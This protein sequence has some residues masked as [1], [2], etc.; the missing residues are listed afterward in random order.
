V[1][2]LAA[3][4]EETLA[5]AVGVVESDAMTVVELAESLVV[6]LADGGEKYLLLPEGS[7]QALRSNV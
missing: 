3:V 5:A 7:R 1:A 4:E 2:V 6:A